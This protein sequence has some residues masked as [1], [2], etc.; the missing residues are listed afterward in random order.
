MVS[1]WFY[2]LSR[3]KTFV[4]GRPKYAQPSALLFF[5]IYLTVQPARSRLI[6]IKDYLLIYY[7]NASRMQWHSSKQ[8]GEHHIPA[9]RHWLCSREAGV[10]SDS[11]WT[12]SN[13]SGLR[14]HTASRCN[15]GGTLTPSISCGRTASIVTNAFI[16]SCWEDCV[17]PS[18]ASYDQQTDSEV[19]MHQIQF[20]EYSQWRRII[21]MYRVKGCHK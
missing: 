9:T 18:G 21:I 16:T 1:K 14:S 8:Q 12:A 2:S 5:S 19:K 11:R 6:P 3:R 4:V 20:Q 13:Q 17:G 15:V 10:I 7:A